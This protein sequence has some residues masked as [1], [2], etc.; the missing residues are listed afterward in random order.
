MVTFQLDKTIVEINSFANPF[1]YKQLT[2]N[3]LLFDFFTKTNNQK[4]IEQYRLEPFEVNVLNK[5]QTMLEKLASLICFS[6]AADPIE[7]I[8]KKIRHFYDL[9]FLMNDAM[10]AEFAKSDKFRTKFDEILEHDK[11]VF[12]EPD[13]WEKKALNE[14]PL[15][16]GFESIWKQVNGIYR[17]ELSALAYTPIPAE[18]KIA[19]QFNEL[20][21]S[22][23]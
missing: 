13:G 1:P 2:I 18:D 21:K 4:Y 19:K 12:D 6:F 16:T 10:C 8:S 14:S 20:I 5:E 15:L 7:S 22:L 23:L 9:Y 3:S 17:T 11:Q